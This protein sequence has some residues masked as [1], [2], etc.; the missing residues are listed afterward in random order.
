MINRMAMLPIAI[1]AALTLAA[2]GGADEGSSPTPDPPSTEVAPDTT[3]AAPEETTADEPAADEAEAGAGDAASGDGGAASDC[4]Q[5]L[6]AD[7]IGSILGTA[8]E[9]S[10]SGQQ[11]Q[12]IYASD[13]VGTFQAYSGSQADEAINTL[14]AVFQDDETKSANGVLLD[15]GRGYVLDGSFERSVVVRGDSG[16]VFVFSAPDSLDVA[17][18]QMAMQAIADLLLT[19]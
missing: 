15:D 1:A 8:P 7:E 13:A 9:I 2:C 17:D 18:I 16:Q 3:A 4:D 5:V 6:T 12:H 19:R 10:G 14:L 11:C